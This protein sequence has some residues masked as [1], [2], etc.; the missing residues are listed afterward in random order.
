MGNLL[1]QGA[2]AEDGGHTPVVGESVDRIR[3]KPIYL[4]VRFEEGQVF[5]LAVLLSF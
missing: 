3:D 1:L 5:T 4:R 2:C